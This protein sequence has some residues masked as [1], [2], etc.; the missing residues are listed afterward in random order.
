[1]KTVQPKA[2][3]FPKSVHVLQTT[4]GDA[5]PSN[6][7]GTQNLAFH[8]ADFPASVHQNRMQLLDTLSD[9]HSIHWLTQVH[10]THVCKISEDSP[11]MADADQAD[12]LVTSAKHI[13]LAIMTADCLP[14]LLSNEDGSEVSAIH[15][16][17]KGLLNGIIQTT[18]ETMSTPAKYAWIGACIHQQNFEVGQEVRQ[19]FLQQDADFATFFQQ[20]AD[21]KYLGDLTGIASQILKAQNIQTSVYPS[22]SY[23]DDDFYSYRKATH[24]QEKAT[25]RMASLI[26]MS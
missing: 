7:Y 24:Q 23:A 20:T 18:I 8:V 21:D 17:W 12:A 26:W 5:L 6:A 2:G 1:M 14:V 3:F 15:A 10:G 19:A 9:V 22:C 13:A 4:V 16:G 11:L 25:G